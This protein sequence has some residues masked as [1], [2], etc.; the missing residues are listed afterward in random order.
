MIQSP[1]FFLVLIDLFDVWVS[2]TLQLTQ[3]ENDLC[4]VRYDVIVES[5]HFVCSN[6]KNV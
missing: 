5:T 6:F 4:R 2:P 1:F 3:I